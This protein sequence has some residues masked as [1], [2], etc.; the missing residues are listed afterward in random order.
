MLFAIYKEM[1]DKLKLIHVAANEFCIGSAEPSCLFGLF[2]Q[3]DLGVKV[4]TF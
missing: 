4:C 1:T 2:G 3:N